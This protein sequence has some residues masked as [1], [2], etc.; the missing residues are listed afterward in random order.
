M[1]TRVRAWIIG[2]GFG[3]AAVGLVNHFLIAKPQSEMLLE[4]R[5]ALVRRNVPSEVETP[6]MGFREFLN[7]GLITISDRLIFPPSQEES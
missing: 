6:R 7:L 1:S 3:T 4:L 5:R 2:A